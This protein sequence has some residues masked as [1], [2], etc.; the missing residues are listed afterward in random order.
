MKALLLIDIQKGL[1]D[2]ALFNKAEF[3]ET[4]N[5]A[6][7]KSRENSY[8]IIFVRHENKML[9]PNTAD[10]DLCGDLL[11]EKSDKIFSKIKGN[12][13]TNKELTA[14]L[15]DKSISDVI[16]GG[17]VTHGCVHH[18]CKGGVQEGL[19]ISLLKGGHTLWG[20]GA[21]SKINDTENVLAN[22]GVSTITIDEI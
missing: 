3:I 12:A 5:N 19:N 2:R 1:T 13:F 10:W 11:V 14:Y 18:T 6:I 22:I 7:K 9:A 4:L 16:V 15:K 17:L 20:K 21:E 8:P